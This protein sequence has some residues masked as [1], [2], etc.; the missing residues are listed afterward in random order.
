MRTRYGGNLATVTARAR[1]P[2]RREPYWVPIVRGS[3]LGY[4]KGA[5]GGTWIVRLTGDDG[6][7]H[8]TALGAADDLNDG[9]GM[10]YRA[11]FDQARKL[12]NVPT[13]GVLKATVGDAL[14][15]YLKKLTAEESPASTI[16]D[17]RCRIDGLIRPEL[18]NVPLAKLAASQLG[19]FL[20]DLAEGRSGETVKRIW[21]TF[22]AALNHARREKLVAHDG[23]WRDVKLPKSAI[24]R[25]QGVSLGR[26][27]P[28][29]AGAVRAGIP[30]P[31]PG[32]AAD[33]GAL[34]RAGGAALPGFRRGDGNS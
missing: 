26:A 32:R 16:Y 8:Y 14:D 6:R 18:G 15:R 25:A 9:N 29:A 20:N 17:A 22:K 24:H 33:R 34:R 5:T 11:A 23:A 21:A 27:K 28:R 30:Q 19:D 4:R 2:Q 12:A 31:D 13:A 10:D 3:A 1:L 7:K